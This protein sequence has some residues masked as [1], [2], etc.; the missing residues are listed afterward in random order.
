MHLNNPIDIEPDIKQKT[1]FA[2]KLHDVVIV[3]VA[4]QVSGIAGKIQ[5]GWMKDVCLSGYLYPILAGRWSQY[6]S[7]KVFFRVRQ[8]SAAP[9]KPHSD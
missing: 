6:V 8:V 2:P 3:G 5:A 9:S 7:E 1:V 4:T